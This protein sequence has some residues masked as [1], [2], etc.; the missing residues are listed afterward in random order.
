MYEKE[1]V[2]TAERGKILDRGG[3]VI[4]EDTLSYRL[5]AVVSPIATTNPEKPR[6]VVD[7]DKKT[8]EILAKYIEMDEANIYKNLTKKIT[9]SNTG[10]LKQPYQVEFGTAGGTS[11]SHEIKTAIEA[12]SLPGI[13]F[14]SDS[15]KILSERTICFTFNRICFKRKTR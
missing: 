8:A 6:H 4:A 12:E 2:L 15:K 11:I 9:D 10:E 5:I 1:A 14:T 7:P 13:L 3:S